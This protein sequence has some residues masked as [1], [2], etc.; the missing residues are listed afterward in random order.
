[1]KQILIAILALIT[2]LFTSCGTTIKGDGNVIKKEYEVDQFEN[3]KI[4]GGYEVILRQ[5]SKSEIVISTD[6]NL[7]EYID[8]YVEDNKLIIESENW[9]DANELKVYIT[10]KSFKNIDLN[11]A[12]ELKSKSKI[13]EKYISIDGSGAVDI[14]IEIDSKKLNIDISGA[15][16]IDLKGNCDKLDVDISGAGELN[17]YDLITKEASIDISGAGSAKVNVS[18]ELEVDITGAGSVAYKGNPEID[19][20]ITGAGSVKKKR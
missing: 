9:L 10:S 6:E 15:S 7:I 8:V 12:V 18:D 3:I 2:V 1:M 4:S 19:E 16:E 5:D 20:H 13:K 17:A 14:D 11:G